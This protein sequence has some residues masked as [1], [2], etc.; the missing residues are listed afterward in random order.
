MEYCV[1]CKELSTNGL[2]TVELR[3]KGSDGINNA[4]KLRGD[5][6]QTFAGQR[7]HQ[8]C[9]QK[10]CHVKVIR[11]YIKKHTADEETSSSA[12]RTLRSSE[13]TF[14]FGERCLF[15]SQ[16]AK[17]TG[18]KRGHD[19]FPVRTLDFQTALNRICEER[20][21]GWAE[22][23][24]GR[25]SFSQ[26]L[27]AAGAIYHQV[28]STNF[29]T[30]KQVPP[31]HQTNGSKRQKTGRP[32][33]KSRQEAFLEVAKYL[34]ENDDEQITVNDLM[35]KMA[36]FNDQ[37]PYS[38][39]YMKEK[40]KEHF[41]EN[42][43]IAS[44]NGKADVVTFRST[45]STILQNFY[46][47]SRD[48]DPEADKIRVIKAAADLIK[49]DI[50]SKDISKSFYP[51]PG[52]ISSL[53]E[54]C[55]FLPETLYLFLRTIFNEKSAERKI[56]SI[57]QAIIQAAR[58]RVLIAPLQIGLAVQMHHHYGSK[59]LID[60]LNSHGFCSSYTEVK[61]FE[62]SAAQTKGT[63]IPGLTP[64]HFV[65]YVADNVD[66]NV[67][68]L[69]GQNTFHGMGIIAAVTPA[70]H[71]DSPIPRCSTTAAEIANIGK[72]DIHY[73][74]TANDVKVPLVYEKLPCL[75]NVNKTWKLD[76]LCS[77]VWPIRSPK[78]NWSGLMQTVSKGSHPGKSSVTFLPMI[79]MDPTNM[80][81]IYSTLKFV[82]A[83]C[84]R[85]HTTP[86]ITFDQPL[87]WKAQL[88]VE[89]EPPDSELRSIILRLGG[90]HAEMSFLGC[91]G[92]IMSGSGIEELL[93]C[94]YASNTVG[95]TLSGKAVQRAFRG[96]LLVENAL[97]AI[98]T[99]DAF[100]LSLPKALPEKVVMESDVLNVEET[101]P[102]KGKDPS[103][104]VPAPGSVVIQREV[105][106]LIHKAVE[107]Y[108]RLMAGDIGI[109]EIYSDSLLDTAKERVDIKKKELANHPTARLWLQYMDMVALLRQFIE[110][111]RTGNWEVH[112]QSLRDMLPFYAAAGH[113][114]YAK[115]VYI[116]L[117]QMLELNSKH[118]DV[119]ELFKKGFHVIRRSDR[120]W[121]GLS[122][123][124]VIEQ[125]LMRS[126]KSSG[127][128]T[129]GR[130]MAES[131]RAQW[132]LS[133]PACASISSA[134]QEFTS[135]CY[136][137]S[138][139][140][141]EMTKTRQAR[142][143]EDSRALLGYLQER[144]PFDCDLSMRN[145]STGITAD[146]TVNVDRAKEV[147]ETILKSMVGNNVQE[148]TF[149]KKNHLVTMGQKKSIKVDGEPLQI[150]P[151]L[152]F[153]RLTTNVA[154][155]FQY[156]LCS[157]PSSLFD[158][159]GLLREA[160]KAQLADDIWT[161]AKGNEMQPPEIAGEMNHV[162]D[163][164][165]LLQRI[166]WKRDETFNSIAKGYVEYIQQKFTNSIV[167][168][169]GYN[170]GPVNFVGSMRL[171][172]KKEHFLSN[173]ENKQRFIDMLS[174]RLQEHGVK[175]LHAESDADLLIVQTA[176]DSATNSATTVVGEDT[177]L[178]VLLC[179][180]ADVKSQP[181]FF[182]S[183]KKQTAKKNHKVWHINR[184]KSVMGPEL[185]LL[186][187]FV[188]AVSGSDTTS[189]LYG[190]GK[191][192]ALRKLRSDSAFKEAA[193]VFTRQSSLEEIVAAGEKALC[194]LYGGRPNE[195]LDVLRYRR[196]CEKVATS[197]TTVQVQSLPPTSAAARYHSARVYLQVQQW[198]GRGKNLNPEDWGW[199]RIQD[200]LHA[201]T[202][203][204]PPAPDNLLKVIRCTCKQGCDS[205]RCSCRKFGIPCSFACSECRGVNCS[206]SSTNLS[207]VLLNV[208]G[209]PLN[210]L[211]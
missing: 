68:T 22:K 42:I 160:N 73:Y 164:G 69:D 173:C 200:R 127:G 4:S 74:K 6:L 83:Q 62:M 59:F 177:D 105:P 61:K 134:M 96:H 203:D 54:N 75:S 205:R 199:L 158:Q 126:V 13:P 163:G 55:A 211:D 176:V 49:T 143:D 207:D 60:S 119:L 66:H 31:S 147:G 185:C 26:D 1:I 63:D 84:K 93:E 191:G 123:D 182:K 57:G 101:E 204:Q 17:L 51:L 56:A 130:G 136:A 52:E 144:N 117:Q 115:S 10:Y 41:G 172:T 187:P 77:L 175:T 23:V 43:V 11:S 141:K 157:Q 36:E 154:E 25:I 184:L 169:D 40:L 82:E 20:R 87:W 47:A 110:A 116:Y 58:P 196:F 103:Q 85:Q 28:C 197:N 125:V 78:P 71:P 14:D 15:C 181:L 210:E 142:D 186:L 195:G 86:I 135:R 183:E 189:R 165:S 45:A 39:R 145:I 64:G 48:A 97:N 206:N 100:N 27:I 3:Q 102:V 76:F 99:A 139:Q 89:S 122:S 124:L 12:S 188:H 70:T 120:F 94:V 72:I 121:A 179:L 98:L 152:L 155:L 167:V 44:I 131:Q 24:H 202:T 112:L 53:E 80:S 35:N 33:D 5:T 32:T 170:A 151:Q 190:V 140:H 16:P 209:D 104:N 153:Q 180:H 150:D 171:K 201:R 38:A 148:Y 128:L 19:V 138:G 109:A 161:V 118:A 137:S 149:K 65:Q 113:N 34:K 194:C 146:C 91:I 88:I 166:P 90:F 192:A 7:V 108:E 159:H 30:G 106:D 92:S 18:N 95:H 8:K 107:L 50:K 193:Y 156:E 198:M 162:I 29:R 111:E 133:M 2:E 129:H 46:D 81:C 114:L 79:D 174:S 132:L 9:R 168:F 178:L 67:C 21:D 208:E 37:E